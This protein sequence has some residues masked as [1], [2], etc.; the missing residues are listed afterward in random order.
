M[1]KKKFLIFIGVLFIILALTISST[2]FIIDVEWFQEVGYLRIY[3]A[4]VLA[5]L[6]LMGPLFLLCFLLMYL[7]SKSILISIEKEFKPENL[8]KVKKV[9]LIFNIIISFI[10]SMSIAVEYWYSILLF[11]NSNVFNYKDP[12][13]NIDVSFYIFKLPLINILY[14]FFKS[15]LF[16]ALLITIGFYIFISLKKYAI[17]KSYMSFKQ[18]LKEFKEILG[19]QAATL[20]SIIIFFIGIGYILKSFYILYSKNGGSFGASFTDINVTLNFYKLIIIV[21]IISSIISFIM[22]RRNKFKPLILFTVIILFLII[23]QPLVY[24]I[25]HKF[26]VKPNEIE[27]ESPYISYNIDATNKG[28]NIDNIEEK[29]FDPGMDLNSTKINNN[30]Q[31][32]SNLKVNSPGPV[33]NFYNQ[34]QEIRSYYSFLDIDTDRYIIDGKYTQVFLA[35]REIDISSIDNWQSKH[36]V[37]THGYGIAMSKVNKVT[38]EG[39]PDFLMKNLPTEN[40]TNIHLK[41]PRIY[42]GEATNDYAIVNTSSGELDY[43][44]ENGDSNY[45]YDDKGGIKLNIF[46]RLLFSLKEQNFKILFSGNITSE[47]KI[48]TN[49]NIL[50]RVEKIAPFLEYDE[51]PYMVINEGKL[52]WIID[53]YTTANNFPYSQP[54]EGINY[55]RN[56]F[57]VIIDAKSGETNYYI[58]DEEDPIV[59]GYSKIFK[60]LFK[61]KEEIP[62]GLQSHFKY[63]KKIFDIQCNVLSTYHIKDPKEFFTLEDVWEVSSNSSDVKENLNNNEGLYLVTQLPG[64]RNEEMILFN[65]FN[66]KSKKNMI[67]MLG[68]RMDGEYYGDLVLFKFSPEKTVYGPYLFRNQILQDPYIYQEISLWEGKG[69]KVEYG[70]TVIL[71]IENSLIYMVPVYLKADV[72]KTIPEM[73]RIILSDGK[74]IV[75]EENLNKAL[76]NLFNYKE[77][78][79]N[80]NTINEEQRELSIKIQDLYNKAIESQTK[81]NWAEYGE[82]IKQLG[83]A[84]EKLNK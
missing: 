36:M 77:K 6:K 57:K 58:V 10:I 3:F 22:L 76:E 45:K 42:F 40:L 65:Y 18:H 63:P 35:P 8:L 52:F 7:L 9:V 20:V 30:K 48:L 73:K 4:K 33:L 67:S 21:S 12:I 53:G 66:M 51:D 62:S 56:S 2:K 46:N 83:E 26:F 1:R 43:P 75:M 16:I 23:V 38:D 72:E 11:T 29:S 24:N 27:Y 41:N 28:F 54:Y 55:I 79:I 64:E 84:I 61:T 39:Q 80:E 44:K 71:P 49:R 81:G 5:I 47:S 74:K 15:I 13:F 17:N 70:E 78:I 25:V 68:A 59:L 19:K 50:D 34:V 60:G 82:Y 32:I 69:S 37:Y 14:N 31:I